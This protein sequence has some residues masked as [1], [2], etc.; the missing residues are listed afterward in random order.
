MPDHIAWGSSGKWGVGETGTL[1]PTRTNVTQLCRDTQFPASKRNAETKRI[2][3]L[4]V[5]FTLLLF[6]RNR[7]L[8]RLSDVDLSL[9]FRENKFIIPL[10]RLA[11]EA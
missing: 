7:V 6:M 11:G 4:V 3:E 9:V 10:L 1:S 8:A 2:L 5:E